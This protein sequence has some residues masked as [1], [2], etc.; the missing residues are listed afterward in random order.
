MKDFKFPGVCFGVLML[1]PIVMA[2]T[3]PNLYRPEPNAFL[4][5]PASSIQG[6]I[7]QVRTDPE[8]YGR[9]AKYYGMDKNQLIAY[10]STLKQ[11]KLATNELYVVY[12]VH[13]D[14]VIRSRLFDLKAGSLIYVDSFGQAVMKKVCGNPMKRGPSN[15]STA[16]LVPEIPTSAMAEFRPITEESPMATTPIEMMVV[17]E[18]VMPAFVAEVPVTPPTIVTPETPVVKPSFETIPIASI[19]PLL[20][21]AAVFAPGGNNAPIPEPA[22]IIAVTTMIGLYGASRARRRNK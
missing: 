7:Q 10:F 12:N 11:A 5:R 15:L 2:K 19:L 6:V 9:F 13:E 21:G 16:A 17:E 4:N 3:D 20:A 22:T 14:G 18:V 1:A 8:V